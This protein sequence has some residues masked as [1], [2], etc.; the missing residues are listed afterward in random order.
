MHKLAVIAFIFGLTVTLQGQS[1]H[2]ED[3]KMNCG[4][5]HTA[6]SWEIPADSW[7]FEKPS[8]PVISKT[9][10]WRLA[11]DSSR[12][13]HYYT[14]FP[15]EGQH[16]SV[17][18]RACHETLVFSEA[19]PECISCHTDMHNMTVGSDCAR[20][21]T[22]ENWL[23]DNITEL[24]QDNGF[25]LLGAHNVASCTDCHI[26]ASNL[27]FNRIG[28]DCINCHLDDYNATTN[29]N[30][31]EAGFSTDCT[32][33]HREDIFDWNTDKVNHDFFPLTKGH[34]IADCAKCHAGGDYSNT[35]TEC[36]ACHQ[37]D[38]DNSQHPNHQSASFSSNCIECHTTDPGWSPARFEQH[39]FEYFPIYSGKH[40]GEWMHM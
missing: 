31:Q 13:N 18:C 15:L 24:H 2:G 5:C 16:V 28:N 30:H 20:C 11:S 17:D 22:T 14:N 39:D 33:C 6:D 34:D 38:F 12:F 8:E 37:T 7:N 9:T 40:E 3:F 23:V 4:A 35:P 1:P 27:E 26:S 19:Q 36:V 29:P 10:G 21:H 25:P 32:Q